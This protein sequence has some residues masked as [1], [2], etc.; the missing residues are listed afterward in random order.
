MGASCTV[1]RVNTPY[2]A[3]GLAVSNLK[4]SPPTPYTGALTLCK[5][6]RK[7]AAFCGVCLREA[8]RGE[9]EEEY[10]HGV[11][12]CCV[13]NE[14]HQTWPE[15]EATCRQCR[16]Q[17][18]WARVNARPHYRAAVDGTRWATLDWETRQSIETFIDLGEGTIQDILQI[19]EEKHWLRSFTK[20]GDMLSTLR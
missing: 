7:A 16:A 15:V 1:C 4:R 6:H 13:E 19:A 20:L 3:E 12:V 8:P 2:N 10:T 17:G 18:F 11:P 14:D 5:E 9:L